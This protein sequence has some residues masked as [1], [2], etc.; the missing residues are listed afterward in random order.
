MRQKLNF[1]DGVARSPLKSF[2]QQSYR[3]RWQSL[4][5]KS[6]IASPSLLTRWLC[7]ET[8]H[9]VIAVISLTLREERLLRCKSFLLHM[10]LNPIAEIQSFETISGMKERLRRPFKI[11]ESFLLAIAESV[12]GVRASAKRK[13]LSLK[14]PRPPSENWYI[15]IPYRLLK[16]LPPLGFYFEFATSFN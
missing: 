11:V 12:T 7:K 1:Q 9:N 16:T 10:F 5:P 14:S 8:V 4:A 15:H 6:P 2:R 13:G 3:F